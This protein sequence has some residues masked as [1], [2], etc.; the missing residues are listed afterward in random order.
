M[1]AIAHCVAIHVE[2]P[3]LVEALDEAGIETPPLEGFDGDLERFVLETLAPL[4]DDGGARAVA[5]AVSAAL[6]YIRYGGD[7]GRFYALQELEEP[8]STVGLR[9]AEDGA[10]VSTEDDAAASAHAATPPLA[11]TAPT[12]FLGHGTNELW[13]AVKDELETHGLVVHE[14]TSVSPVGITTPARLV[15][16]LDTCNFAVLLLT[17]DDIGPDGTRARQNVVHEVGLFQ[18]RHGFQRVAV[19]L[20]GGVEEFSNIHG[21]GQIREDASG[22]IVNEVLKQLRREFPERT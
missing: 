10:V 13:R 9:I 12:V 20:V 6:E 18:G 14:F 1:R 2:F 17:P 16:L 19:V 22:A 4:H 7:R 3:T 8:L 11:S 5:E 15:E 21:L